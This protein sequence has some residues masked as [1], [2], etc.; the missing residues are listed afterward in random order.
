MISLLIAVLVLAV[1]C[2]I[3]TLIPLPPP[4]KTIAW[5]VIGVIFIIW[6]L[7]SVPGLHVGS[8]CGRY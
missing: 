1:I 3:I 5:L 8:L 7:E 6:L 4:F 2:Y